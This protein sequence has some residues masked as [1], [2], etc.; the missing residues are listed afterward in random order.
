MA[1]GRVFCIDIDVVFVTLYMYLLLFHLIWCHWVTL[2]FVQ[3]H[4]ISS[5]H[6]FH[7]WF[8]RGSHTVNNPAI[9]LYVVF[10]RRDCM[11]IQRQS[12]GFLYFYLI[13]SAC[14]YVTKH[15]VRQKWILYNIFPLSLTWS[16][17][18]LTLLI[19]IALLCR[20]IC[21]NTSKFFFSFGT[22]IS[23]YILYRLLLTLS[24][25]WF[26]L[27]HKVMALTLLGG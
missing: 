6:H 8:C 3:W 23:Q 24:L 27:I 12:H 22:F 15:F 17:L 26:S 20:R 2:L 11:N 7:A 25:S 5:K 16:P 14:F 10:L 19:S 1:F 18:D 4:P 13:F 21:C 9:N